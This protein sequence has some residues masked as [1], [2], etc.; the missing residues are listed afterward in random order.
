MNY[1]DELQKIYNTAKPEYSNDF[2]DKKIVLYGA[3]SLGHM[4]CNL[5][6]KAGIT[7][8]YVVDKNAT[9][10]L[11]GLKILKPDEIPEN[12]K[13]KF[14][15]LICI[16]T[17]P[18]NEIV[19][20]LKAYGIKNTLQFYTYAY[21]K[22]PQLL[23]NGWTA[24][25]ITEEE[26]DQI[27][28][29][30]KNLGHDERSLCHYLQF[31][32]WKIRGI[33]HI[34]KEYPVLS[35]KKY[36][37]SPCLPELSE[38]EILLDGGCHYGQTIEKFIHAVQNKYEKIYAFEPDNENLKICKEKYCDNRIIY[39]TKAIYNECK[40][41]KFMSGLGFA[42]K[43]EEYGNQEVETATIDS[44]N[45]TP[46]IIKL[47]TESDELKGLTGAKETISR[48]HP[49]LMIMADHT[50]ESLYKIPQYIQ[51]FTGYKLYFN[52]HDYCG[53]T[54][55]YYGIYERRIK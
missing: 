28:S 25:D 19:K 18:Y 29:V 26:K 3:G 27:L 53:N 21:I 49:I 55:V 50:P 16:A 51:Q 38:H 39:S 23:L 37:G 5:L 7:P 36:F 44:L 9:G 33:E 14:L 43:V 12:D 31:L 4:A 22:F 46:T 52:L 32:W 42:S 8:E 45:I 13:D 54:A 6:A 2:L 41:T 34:Y 40:K 17:V 48:C 1:K 15:F 47:H 35:G 20:S 10:N 24:Y 11:E 30:C